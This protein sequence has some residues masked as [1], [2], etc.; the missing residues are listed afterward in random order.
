MPPL[1]PCRCR[2]EDRVLGLS[3]SKCP[4]HGLAAADQLDAQLRDSKRAAEVWMWGM[5]AVAVLL[6]LSVVVLLATGQARIAVVVIVAIVAVVWLRDRFRSHADIF[7]RA[8]A[9]L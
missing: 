2:Q 3:A 6:T 7:A 8:R 1:P 5:T 9:L 4:L